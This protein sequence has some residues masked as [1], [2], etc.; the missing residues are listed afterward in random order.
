MDCAK[1]IFE[2][3]GDIPVLFISTVDVF[4]F[5]KGTVN[6]NTP[7]KPVSNYGRSKMMAE[8]EVRKR[9]ILTSFAS[10]RFIQTQ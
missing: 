2:V 5:T 4:G 10:L 9:G 3:A 6:V 1:N 7:M 8:Q